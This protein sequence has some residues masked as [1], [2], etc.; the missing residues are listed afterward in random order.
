MKLMRTTRLI[1]AAFALMALT[2]THAAAQTPTLT[3]TANGATVTIEWTDLQS[4]GAVGYQLEVGGSLSAS[5]NLPASVTRIVVAAPPGTYSLRVRGLAATGG[6]G[7]Y[8]NI[9]S[10]TVGTSAPGPS[11]VPGPCSAP[12]APTISTTVSGLSVVVNWGAAAG[13]TGYR[14]E[15]SRT[16]AGTELVQTTG[17]STTSYSQYVGMVGTFYV[18]VTAINSCGATSSETVAFTLDNTTPT[19]SGPRTP[20]PAA[21]QRLPVPTYGA[22]V[23][24]Q[25]A[26]QYPGDLQNSCTE[27]GGTNVFMFRVVQALRAIDS[28]WGLNW[29]RGNR[30]DLSQDIVNYNY[31]AGPDED[32]TNVYIFDIIGGHCGARAYPT[33]IDQTAATRNAGTIGRWTL[34]PYL[35]AGFPADPR[36]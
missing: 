19:G 2:A 31:G 20:D 30:G 8:S 17:A 4:M 9:A 33:W 11:P 35:R 24:E 23:V 14:V 21:G 3:V 7:P 22:T 26:R 28:R 29:K 15:F 34:Q 1:A 32:T 5:V 12:S 16:A 18:R 27:H 36:R 6:F 13:A 25:L 10:V